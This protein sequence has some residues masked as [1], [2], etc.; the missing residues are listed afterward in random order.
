MAL[1]PV[2]RSTS[3]RQ[4]ALLRCSALQQHSRALPSLLMSS[5]S[6]CENCQQQRSFRS[7]ES[8]RNL[9]KGN[10]NYQGTTRRFASESGEA[11]AKENQTI[12]GRILGAFQYVGWLAT[13]GSILQVTARN[14]YGCCTDNIDHQ[15]FFKVCKMPDTFQSWFLVVHL[16]IWMCYV[17]LNMLGDDGKTVNQKM[18]ELMWEDVKERIKQLGIE[19]TK[20]RKESFKELSKQF[21]GLMIA[22]NKALMAESERDLADAFWRNLF[23][24]KENTSRRN[25]DLIMKYVDKQLD[26]LESM[27]KEE[28][29]GTGQIEWIPLTDLVN[30]TTS[31]V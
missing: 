1:V 11:V 27:S 12:G 21:Y 29:L 9:S 30:E 16:H 28:L 7:F 18:T 8:Q 19:D 31:K 14:I 26:L 4:L 23:D 5:L 25:L 17:R 22:Y 13:R 24:D 3:C 2:I 6:T 10:F 15:E 20:A